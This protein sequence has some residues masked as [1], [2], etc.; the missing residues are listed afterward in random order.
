MS[1]ENSFHRP[2]YFSGSLVIMMACMKRKVP[3]CS[4][5]M[6][7]I[8]KLYRQHVEIGR[9]GKN[10]GKLPTVVNIDGKW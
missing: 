6:L 8:I 3:T 1:H 2:W 10:C 5:G 7:E 9:C 4:K